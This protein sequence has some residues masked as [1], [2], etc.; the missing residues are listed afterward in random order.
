MKLALDVHYSEREAHVAAVAFEDWEDPSPQWTVT[1]TVPYVAKYEPGAFYKREL[2][3]LL[4]ILEEIP[5]RPTLV[6]VDAYVD[7]GPNRP[8]LGRR[9]YEAIGVPVVG[10]AKTV[11]VGAKAIEVHRGHSRRALYV[12]AAGVDARE[13]A[14]AIARMHGSARMPTLMKLAD[15]LA[16]SS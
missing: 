3:A 13:A 14:E 10:V 6:L 2:P 11:F 8:G 9:L 5:T 12:T 4:A 15:R 7:L 16:R 1:A